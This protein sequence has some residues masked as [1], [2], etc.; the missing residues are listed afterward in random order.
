MG[1]WIYRLTDISPGVDIKAVTWTI[2]HGSD[3][4]GL[5][6]DCDT[7]IFTNTLCRI[8]FVSNPCTVWEP[9]SIP[10]HTY[11]GHLRNTGLHQ[12]EVQW[13]HGYTFGAGGKAS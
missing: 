2:D 8:F 4:A 6:W 12:S 9:H 7:E 10:S 13:I 11:L 1:R 3:S 5:R